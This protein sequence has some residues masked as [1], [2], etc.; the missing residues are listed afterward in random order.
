[1]QQNMMNVDAMARS[2]NQNLE[3]GDPVPRFDTEDGTA[4]FGKVDISG[5]KIE[6]PQGKVQF[7]RKPMATDADG[8]S[9]QKVSCFLRQYR[10]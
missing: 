6:A 5:N 9:S 7:P 1:M 2:V 8:C 4:V 3:M 10:P